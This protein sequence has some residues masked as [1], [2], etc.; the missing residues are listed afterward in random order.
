MGSLV[1]DYNPASRYRQHAKVSTV[2]V[3]PHVS[4]LPPAPARLPP[5]RSPER[6]AR[7]MQVLA[8]GA[9]AKSRALA[10]QLV[11]LGGLQVPALRP[12]PPRPASA[13]RQH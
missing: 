8:M 4:R 11:A 2:R 6:C 1:P 12:A 3:L 13:P 5:A 9:V 10:S 7:P